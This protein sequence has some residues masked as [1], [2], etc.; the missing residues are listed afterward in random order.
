MS[1]HWAEQDIATIVVHPN[2]VNGKE[3][4]DLRSLGDRSVASELQEV[5]GLASAIN[6]KVDV[7]KLLIC[8]KFMLHI[9]WIWNT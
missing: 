3:A 6:L 2:I 8:Q 9:F 7:S 5:I 1:F 4:G